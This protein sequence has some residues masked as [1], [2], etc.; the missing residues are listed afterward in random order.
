[1][2]DDDIRNSEQLVEYILSLPGSAPL[3]GVVKKG[4]RGVGIIDPRVEKIENSNV[5]MHL[6]N[7]YRIY[8]EDRKKIIASILNIKIVGLT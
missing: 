6:F 1:M 8:P 4:C 2:L 3:G 5:V 7:K